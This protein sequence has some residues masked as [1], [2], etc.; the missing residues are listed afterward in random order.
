MTNGSLMKVESIAEAFCNTYDLHSAIISF[1]NQFL[2]FLRVDVLHK[3]YCTAQTEWV[4]M[5]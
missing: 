3:F 1:E 2:V 5:R 4:S